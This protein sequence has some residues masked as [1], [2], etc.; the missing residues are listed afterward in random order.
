ML[1][2]SQV[3]AVVSEQS[4]HDVVHRHDRG[5]A[6]VVGDDLPR[7]QHEVVADGRMGVGVVLR[8]EAVLPRETIEIRHRRAVQGVGVV[9]ILFG[10]EE[11]VSG[12]RYAN[13]DGSGVLRLAGKDESERNERQAP[14]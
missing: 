8:R 12:L 3:S 13:T 5:I 9:V 7:P 10:Y 6:V 11:D 1:F 2:L 14:V 4:P